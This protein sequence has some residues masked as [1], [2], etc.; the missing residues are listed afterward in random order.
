ML[1]MLFGF[2]GP[3]GLI[4][5]AF[6]IWMLY[7]CLK[8]GRKERSLWLWVMIF[9]NVIGAVLY[10]CMCWAPRHPQFKV[11]APLTVR[12]RLRDELWQAEAAVKHI[13]KAHQYI[14][15]GDVLYLMG[16]KKE[17]LEAYQQALAQEPNH[18]KA[19]WGAAS[20]AC[21]LKD[22]AAAKEY[23]V[24]LIHVQPSYSYGE[25]SLAY[26]QVL[27]N[28]GEMETAIAH[29]QTHLRAWS[30]PEAFLWLAQAHH[31][32]GD[33][34]E[35]RETLETMII[36]VKSL[37]PFQYRKNRHFVRQGERMLRAMG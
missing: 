15:L 32:Q 25:A 8:H 3:I 10:F 1:S 24:R 27:L 13:G 20:V 16:D 12:R 33:V 22:F 19:L 11:L 21:H 18:P 30:H 7:D 28:L 4:G 6:W 31:Q 2:L 35:A 9:L 37:V 5:T 14:K 26:G 36:K 17:S 34:P 29:L 23:L